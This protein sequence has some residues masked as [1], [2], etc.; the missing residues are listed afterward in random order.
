MKLNWAERWVVNNPLRVIQQRLEMRWLRKNSNLKPGAVVLE[1]GCGRGAG[2][3][4][5]LREFH[6]AV[7]QPMDLDI[8]M[9]R[10]ARNYLSP[11]L[12]RKISFYVGDILRLPYKDEA[13]D[14]VFGFG[15]LHHIPNWQSGL[16]EIARVLKTGGTYFLEEIYPSLYQNFITKHILLHPRENRFLSQGLKQALIAVNLHLENSLELPK[17]GILGISI[18]GADR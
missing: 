1:V 7:L 17:I 6:P 2:A 15:V 5:I 18:K 11:E 14:A 13:L 12:G 9:I 4:L 8:E 3:G 10:K 16:L